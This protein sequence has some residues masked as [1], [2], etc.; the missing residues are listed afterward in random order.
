MKMHQYEDA[1]PLLYK[2]T[3]LDETSTEAKN[4]LAF[5][6]LMLKQTA[7]AIEIYSSIANQ[8][9]Q[10]DEALFNLAS[11]HFV[12]GNLIEAYQVYRRAYLILN[13]NDKAKSLKKQFVDLAKELKQIGIDPKRVE[14]MYDAVV[15]GANEMEFI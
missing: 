14:M 3:Y 5:C 9:P 4:N 12:D 10:S 8:N 6:Q 11:A 13:Q 7:K 1:I 2:S 15:T